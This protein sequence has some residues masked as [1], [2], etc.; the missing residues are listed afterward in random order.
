MWNQDSNL[1]G[2]GLSPGICIFYKFPSD[3]NMS[4]CWESMVYRDA[5]NKLLLPSRLNFL[6]AIYQK[7]STSVDPSHLIILDIPSILGLLHF[8]CNLVIYGYMQHCIHN[9][10]IIFVVMLLCYHI[11]YYV[12]CLRLHACIYHPHLLGD[13]RQ[14]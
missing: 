12:T 5:S 3:S 11:C 4:Q 2:L 6:H 13:I 1:N 14:L 8:S 7:G 10:T 9:V